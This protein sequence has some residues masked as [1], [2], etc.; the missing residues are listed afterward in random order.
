[1][2]LGAW[3]GGL[4]FDMNGDYVQSFLNSSIAGVVNLL[5]LGLLYVY[6]DPRALRA[7]RSLAHA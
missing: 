3:Q 1:M 6:T 5:I 2:A 7:R 4:F